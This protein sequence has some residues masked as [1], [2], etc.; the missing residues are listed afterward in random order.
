[1]QETED[2]YQGADLEKV[3]GPLESL[4]DTD[5]SRQLIM[6]VLSLSSGSQL[7]FRRTLVCCE[8]VKG[9]TNF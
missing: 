7:R 2:L 9:A 3:R 4:S 8:R 5:V 6:H 1:M